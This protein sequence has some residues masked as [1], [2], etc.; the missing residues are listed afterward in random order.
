M[1]GTKSVSSANDL[2]PGERQ[3]ITRN[4]ATTHVFKCHTQL[5]TV[6]RKRLERWPG[7]DDLV[8]SV[9]FC[10]SDQCQAFSDILFVPRVNVVEITDIMNH[11][12]PRVR[13]IERLGLCLPE[14]RQDSY[15]FIAIL[16]RCN[17]NVVEG[18]VTLVPDFSPPGDQGFHFLV[19]QHS[20]RV[21]RFALVPDC[22]ADRVR[23]ERA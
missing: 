23:Y 22:T 8:A 4:Q 12:H 21:I 11:G 7:E 2:E 5:V 9:R 20:F 18:K 19:V 17:L 13:D 1:A 6:N 14:D 3:A 15:G 10:Q 16:K